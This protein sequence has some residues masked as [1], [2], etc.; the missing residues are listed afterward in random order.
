MIANSWTPRQTETKL[1]WTLALVHAANGAPA[2]RV[3][4]LEVVGYRIHQQSNT[5]TASLE[6][7]QGDGRKVQRVNEARRHASSAG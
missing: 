7:R 1:E 3:F 2:G 5:R 4:R 6:Q